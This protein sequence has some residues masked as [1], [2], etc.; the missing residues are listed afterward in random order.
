MRILHWNCQGLRNSLTIPYLKDINHKHKIDI[1]FLVETKNKDSYVQQLGKDLHFSHQIL[2]SPDGLSGGL[3]IF[4][5]NT[6]QCEVLSPPSLHYTDLYITEGSN[7]FCLTYIY[8]HPER[9]PRQQ[10]WQAMESYIKA[11]LYQSKARLVLGDF[12]EIKNNKEKVGGPPKAEWQ[13]TN[14]RRM[15]KASGLHEVKTFGGIFTWIGNRSSGTVKSKLDRALATAEWLDTHPKAMAQLL[16][17][18][19]SDHRPLLL[20]TNNNKWR[21]MKLFRYDNRWRYND[22]FYSR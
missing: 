2:V 15:L 19:G 10:M 4:W 9:K 17:W 1:M 12:N 22:H 3:A 6:V 13:F 5:R 11:G 21:G 20:Q 14:F 8:G 18:V 16:D 7:T